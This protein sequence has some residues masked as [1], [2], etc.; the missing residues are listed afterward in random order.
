MKF[1]FNEML[2]FFK[3]TV[4]KTLICLFLVRKRIIS[5]I[6][7]TIKKHSHFY[8][9]SRFDHILLEIE[10]CIQLLQH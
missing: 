1:E 10:K 9:E 5:K 6:V 7:A 4:F 3:C 2:N 8:K